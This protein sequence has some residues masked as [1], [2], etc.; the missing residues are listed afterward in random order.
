MGGMPKW[1]AKTREMAAVDLYFSLQDA[2]SEADLVARYLQALTRLRSNFVENRSAAL[3]N[4][5]WDV[6]A[7]GA[8]IGGHFVGDWIHQLYPTDPAQHA[9]V[10]GRFWPQVASQTVVEHIRWGSMIAFHKA[11]GRD[12]L[13]SRGVGNDYIDILFESEFHIGVNVDGVLPLAM[14]WNCVAATGEDYFEVDA[15]RG[16]T[17]VELAIATPRPYGHGSVMSLVEEYE[18]EV[19]QPPPMDTQS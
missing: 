5:G 19:R 18:W 2:G 15:L 3:E 11:L 12:N 4:T 13:S 7:V 16:P 17:V 10:G 8:S 9:H 14:S 6:S 1:F